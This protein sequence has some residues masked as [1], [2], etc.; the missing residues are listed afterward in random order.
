VQ[1]LQK[2]QSFHMLGQSPIGC[3]PKS[4]NDRLQ[5]FFAVFQGTNPHV[6]S[7]GDITELLWTPAPEGCLLRVRQSEKATAHFHGFRKED[8]GRLTEEASQKL[9]LQLKKQAL[10][11]SGH[12]WGS[13]S[14]KGGSVCFEVQHTS[15]IHCY[16]LARSFPTMA[17][18]MVVPP[19]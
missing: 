7:K 17:S 10:S 2:M 13:I 1:C 14:L 4:F 5:C 8:E 16:H 15:L 18:Q 3:W 6:W 12:N 19:G 9:G 11:L